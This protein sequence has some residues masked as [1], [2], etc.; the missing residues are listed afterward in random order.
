MG[1]EGPLP[2]FPIPSLSLPGMSGGPYFNEEG[3]VVGINRG[4]R[5][6]LEDTQ[7]FIGV[8]SSSCLILIPI[9]NANK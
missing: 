2:L 9:I 4:S 8:K 5:E 3:K 1:T 7:V 6:S